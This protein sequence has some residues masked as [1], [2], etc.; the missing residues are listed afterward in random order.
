M[1]TETGEMHWRES[2]S[3]VHFCCLLQ[4][5]FFVYIS[6]AALS[7]VSNS[8]KSLPPMVL[9]CDDC[10]TNVNSQSQLLQHLASPKHMNRVQFRGAIRGR[11]H[12]HGRGWGGMLCGPL[13]LANLMWA[14]ITGFGGKNASF[15]LQIN[16][17]LILYLSQFLY[18]YSVPSK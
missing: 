3:F 4:F 8:M 9:Y 18:G 15:L 7:T 1:A 14:P 11:G 12:S 6:G 2:N 10:H 5:T 13:E 16:F 17:Y